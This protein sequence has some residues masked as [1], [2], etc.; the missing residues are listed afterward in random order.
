M[1]YSNLWR[2]QLASKV[3]YKSKI[4]FAKKIVLRGRNFPVGTEGHSSKRQ[5]KPRIITAV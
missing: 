4:I 5:G 2:M 1:V 3:T